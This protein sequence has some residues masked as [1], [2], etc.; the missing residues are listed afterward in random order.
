[1]PDKRNVAI[2]YLEPDFAL[3]E[4]HKNLVFKGHAAFKEVDN[5]ADL[6]ALLDS[7]LGPAVAIVRPGSLRSETMLSLKFNH[8][9]VCFVALSADDEKVIRQRHGGTMADY[10]YLPVEACEKLQHYKLTLAQIASDAG[11]DI[12]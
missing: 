10:S 4:L 7:A 11:I 9:Q 3:R 8:P 6:L 12:S 1:M 2:F 5:E